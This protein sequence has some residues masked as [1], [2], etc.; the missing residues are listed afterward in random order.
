MAG[1]QVRF[2]DAALPAHAELLAVRGPGTAPARGGPGK[3]EPENPG[4]WGWHT[5]TGQAGK[6]VWAALSAATP[7]SVS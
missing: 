5:V 4:R 7:S 1:V 3:L 2:A 6:V